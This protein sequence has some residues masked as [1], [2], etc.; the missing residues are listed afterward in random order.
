[1]SRTLPSLLGPVYSG[2]LAPKHLADLRK[3][4]LT[5]ETIRLHALRSVPPD[6]IR[7]LLGWDTPRIESAYLIP[8]P[9][10]SEDGWLDHIVLR[11]FPP[12]ETEHGTMKY[13]QP[14]CTPPRLYMPRLN[15]DAIMDA[16]TPLW[17]TEGQKKALA[18][19]QLGLAA[20]GIQGVEG[21]HTRGTRELLPE[22][23]A[24]PL[25]GRL[26]PVVPDGDFEWNPD[27]QRAVR[28]CANALRA[29]GAQPRRVVVPAPA[30]VSA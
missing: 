19:A 12:M 8:Y 21:W 18:L 10:L 29:R 24:L 14:K 23:S 20:V 4:G 3:S 22:F 17:I 5:D 16:A 15:R 27:V 9:S 26:V 30:E 11:L 13:A 7:H 2:A 6:Q 28:R 25:Q 1:M